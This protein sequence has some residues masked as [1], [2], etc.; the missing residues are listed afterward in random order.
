MP[1]G[2]PGIEPEGGLKLMFGKHCVNAG[3]TVGRVSKEPD[4]S[5]EKKRPHTVSVEM[6]CTGVIQVMFALFE[7]LPPDVA[8]TVSAPWWD[9][10]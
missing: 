8:C 7:A 9:P 10:L 1:A 4:P 2:V 3:V 5:E 6:I